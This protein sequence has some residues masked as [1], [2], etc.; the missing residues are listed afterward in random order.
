MEQPEAESYIKWFSEIGIEDVPLVGGKTASLGEM[1]RELEPK[2]VKVPDGFA[3]TAA[4][5]WHLL[6]ETGLDQFI[7]AQLRD[8]DTNDVKQ[9]QKR[10]A[11]IR[12]AVLAAKLPIRFARADFASL[13]SVVPA[14]G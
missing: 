8:L 2:G 3:I 14:C 11:A 4:G 5:Y 7:A 10:G 9:L 1:F 13:R 6:R 12:E